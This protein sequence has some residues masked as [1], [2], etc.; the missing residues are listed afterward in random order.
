MNTKNNQRYRNMDICMKAAM[1]ELMQKMPF[2]KITVKSICQR[3]GVNRGTFYSHYAD[4]YDMM[5]NLEEY[6]SGEL[7]QLVE[8]WIEK[9]NGK[10]PFL[11]YLQYI[12]EH[13]YVYQVTLSNRKTLPIKKSFQPL[14]EQIIFPLCKA[15]GITDE[16]EITYYNICFQSGIIKVF[17]R[18]VE[19]GCKKD[20]K[21]MNMILT[22]CIPMIGYD[23]FRNHT[24]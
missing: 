5:D 4:I 3:A 12:K 11:P 20:E 15:A 18:W 9:N 14:L 22:N 10:S 2:E 21:T 17:V 24:K 1:L 8:E 13:Q 7:L 16:E 23:L 6:L 19:T